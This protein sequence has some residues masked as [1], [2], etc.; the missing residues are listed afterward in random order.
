MA[1]SSISN[2]QF[3]SYVYLASGHARDIRVMK[4]G[5]ANDVRRR[6]T[7]IKLKVDRSFDVGDETWAFRVEDYLREIMVLNCAKPFGGH[8]WFLFDKAIYHLLRTR[9][10]SFVGEGIARIRETELAAL[11]AEI[12]E[13]K[14]NLEQSNRRISFLNWQMGFYQGVLEAAAWCYAPHDAAQYRLLGEGS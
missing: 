7:Q 1:T 5:K 9:F 13:H 6:E 14:K 12:D 10:Y 11:N 8:D 4:I 2:P 3:H